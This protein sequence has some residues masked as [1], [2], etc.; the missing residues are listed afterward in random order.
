MGD[1]FDKSLVLLIM[2]KRYEQIC[3]SGS[4][5]NVEKMKKLDYKAF[6]SSNL[7]ITHYLT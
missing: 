6:K 5:N 4:Q 7:E 2:F 3:C 1:N